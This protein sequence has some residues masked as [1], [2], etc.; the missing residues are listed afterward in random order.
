VRAEIGIHIATGC[1]NTILL[2]I[3]SLLL[4]EEKSCN[5]KNNA[6][7]IKAETKQCLL[8]FPTGLVYCENNY[9]SFRITEVS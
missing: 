6:T 5:N 2:I 8:P 7:K 1:C 3:S 9:F 4:R